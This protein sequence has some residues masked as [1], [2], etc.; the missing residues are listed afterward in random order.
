MILDEYAIIPDIFD[1]SSYSSDNL[2]PVCLAHLKDILL[3]EALVRDL[4]DGEWSKFVNDN[5][6]RWHRNGLE[7]F[8]KIA[9]QNRLYSRT[10][11]TL[12]R[13]GPR[14]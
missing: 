1:A 10:S 3:N 12:N 13:T 7:L 4:R 5:R 2:V 6:Q 11:S 14:N 9:R 8:M